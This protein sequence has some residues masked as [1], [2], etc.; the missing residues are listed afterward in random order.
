MGF[1]QNGLRKVKE[2]FSSISKIRDPI[3]NGGTIAAK[4][5]ANSFTNFIIGMTNWDEMPEEDIFEQM[6]AYEPEV[7]GGIDKLGTMVGQCFQF[8][9]YANPEDIFI[10]GKAVPSFE[11]LEKMVKHANYM[12][13]SLD[14]TE[15]M[16]VYGE[17]LPMF[18]NI[19]IHEN[20]D[21]YALT[22][23]PNRKVTLLDSLDRIT[24]PPMDI[25]KQVITTV[26]Y[27]VTDERIPNLQKEYKIEECYIVRIRNTPLWMQDN[28]KRMTFGLYAVSPL[29][30]A[31]IPVWQKR[32]I[33]AI[34]AMWRW[35]NVPRDHHALDAEMYSLDK[36]AGAG[37]I[38]EMMDAARA[39]AEKDCQAYADMISNKLPDQGYVTLNTVEIK[40]IE[41]SNTSYMAPNELFGQITDQIWGAIN[42]PKSIVTGSSDSSY[43]SE[44]LISNYTNTKVVQIA[45]KVSKPIL[46]NIKKRLLAI[47]DTYPVEYLQVKLDFTLAA[48]EIDQVKKAA[49]MGT[50]GVYTYDEVRAVTKHP[51]LKKEQYGQ[52]VRA[53]ATVGSDGDYD[54]PEPKYPETSGSAN[55]H[56]TSPG[57]SKAEKSTGS[58]K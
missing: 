8:F 34:D 21:T 56:A 17:L 40:P 1:V 37:G 48:T 51:K 2:V 13:R 36:F 12:A 44:V 54:D 57:M 9:E 22:V 20:P 16:E 32:I 5:I 39:A 35:A 14:V 55:Q 23:L 52:L 30:R 18:G 26:N 41:H 24:N 50:T 46:E 10:P 45:R 11:V 7:G 58:S 49:A 25:D 29:Q 28:M 33:M 15:S 6:Y 47:D 53:G 3:F 38:T 42:V 19:Y 27:I 4:R 43:A 31:I